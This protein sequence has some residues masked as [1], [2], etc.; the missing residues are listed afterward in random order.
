MRGRSDFSHLVRSRLVRRDCLIDICRS[1]FDKLIGIHRVRPSTLVVD[2]SVSSLA[3]VSVYEELEAANG[4]VPVLCVS[5][6]AAPRGRTTTLRTK[7]STCIAAPVD[8][9]LVL[10]RVGIFL[11]EVGDRSTSEVLIF[12]SIALDRCDQAMC[13]NNRR[14]ALATGR[15]SL[16]TCFLRRPGRTLGGARVVSTI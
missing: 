15:F 2:S 5:G 3:T 11:E 16:L 8:L 1:N 4:P 10:T 14:L 13:H 6:S 9:S 12:S 7:T